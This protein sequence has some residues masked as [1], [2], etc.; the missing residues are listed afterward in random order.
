MQRSPPIAQIND[1]MS[2]PAQSNS[3]PATTDPYLRSVLSEVDASIRVAALFFIVSAVAWLIISTGLTLI[4]AYQS[5]QPDF[6]SGCEFVTYGRLYPASVN[7]ML[8][9]WGCNVIFAIS[10]W[11]IAR[12]SLAPICNGA[13]LVVAGVFWNLGLSVGLG[14]ILSG[15]LTGAEFLELPGYATPLL[16]FAYTL[17]AIW[18]IM[19]FRVRR[20]QGVYVSQWYIL[21]ALFWFPWI[22]MIAQFMVVWFP[23]RGVVQSII[24]HWFMYNVHN[25]WLT[26]I[27]LATAY[28]IIPKVLGRPIYS[29]TLALLGFC[30]LALLGSWTGMAHLIGGPIPIWMSSVGV[31]ASV[32]MMI[33]VIT[34]TLNLYLSVKG[35]GTDVWRSPALRFVMFGVLSYFFAGMIGALMSLRSVNEITHFTTFASGQ[36]QYLLYGFFAMVMFGG[37]YF[38]LPRLTRREWPSATLIYLHF[39]GSAAGITMMVVALLVGGWLAGNQM[40]DAAVPFA[41]VVQSMVPWLKIR[42]ISLIFLTA[43]HLAFAINFCWMLSTTVSVRVKQGPTLLEAAGPVEDA[44]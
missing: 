22:Y 19:A 11:I 2:N 17:I 37:V 42:L 26:P 21:A 38:M 28:Y 18:G 43:G 7:A 34:V 33:P 44:L 23:V 25:L 29:N 30:S 39:W 24:S 9:G 6:M 31:V 14:G 3:H 13:L 20:G 5:Y 32:M 27:A 10:L 35:A 36:T 41:D 4:T 12:L 16:L 40:N 8:F 15:D 1:S